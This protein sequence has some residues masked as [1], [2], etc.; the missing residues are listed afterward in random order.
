[1]ITETRVHLP[2]LL[3]PVFTEMLLLPA[4]AIA[5]TIAYQ[6]SE[7][8]IL[9]DVPTWFVGMLSWRG[10][11]IPIVFLEQMESYVSWN[12]V[13]RSLETHKQP[14]IA[15]VNRITK[16]NSHIETQKFRQYPFFAM[17][18]EGAP[19]W[20]R[21]FKES[22]TMND[23]KQMTDPRMIMEIKIEKNVAC[24]PNL[25]NAWK[26]IDTLPSRLQWLGKIGRKTGGLR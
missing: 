3:L 26:I 2:C 13:E 19:K 24:V 17:V 25:E 7:V 9:P 5:E 21:V 11:Q 15:V 4:S 10:I 18:L 14:Y 1:M 8:E 23:K 22:L 20:I 6:K 16:I 12:G